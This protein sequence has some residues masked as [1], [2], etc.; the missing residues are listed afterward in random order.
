M[1]FVL[2]YFGDLQLPIPR[3]I[4]SGSLSFPISLFA[5]L[6][7]VILVGYSLSLGGTAIERTA[8]K[9]IHRYEMFILAAICSISLLGT[10]IL[11]SES[12]D[13]YIGAAGRNTLGYIG[14]LLWGRFVVGASAA[15]M[16]PVTAVLFCVSFGTRSDG[17][18]AWWAW[19]L[20]STDDSLSWFISLALLFGATTWQVGQRYSTS[21]QTNRVHR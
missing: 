9:P 11:A 17:S 12:T 13:P 3:V 14:L 19:P 2:V 7:L 8:V 15:T 21:I 10:A 6:S 16:V 5:P 4:A 18:V 1:L 20:Q